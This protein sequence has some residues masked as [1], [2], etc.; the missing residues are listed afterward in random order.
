MLALPFELL[1]WLII[2]NFNY[3]KLSRCRRKVTRK[4]QCTSASW[5]F[6]T[7]FNL[8]FTAHLYYL[9]SHDALPHLSPSTSPHLHSSHA[10]ITAAAGPAAQGPYIHATHALTSTLHTIHASLHTPTRPPTLHVRWSTSW[11]EHFWW[12]YKNLQSKQQHFANKNLNFFLAVKCWH[13]K[14]WSHKKSCYQTLFSILTLNNFTQMI[15]SWFSRL[16]KIL[17]ISSFY[18]QD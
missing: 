1:N 4:D 13:W 8:F 6:L 10:A 3:F 12:W 9:G 15:I 17:C 16:R 11:D 18:A 14:H 7:L 2:N 5:F